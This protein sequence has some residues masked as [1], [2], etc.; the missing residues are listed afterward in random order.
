MLATGRASQSL[1][2]GEPEEEIGRAAEAYN[3]KG[4]DEKRRR[5][6]RLEGP[7]ASL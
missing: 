4:N 2:W 3:Y 1:G 5:R 6:G 7:A